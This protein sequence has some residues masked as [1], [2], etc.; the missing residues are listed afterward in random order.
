MARVTCIQVVQVVSEMDHQ[1]RLLQHLYSSICHCEAPSVVGLLN[2]DS[3]AADRCEGNL[4]D[5][6]RRVCHVSNTAAR[7]R[8]LA[9]SSLFSS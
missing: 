3:P 2:L 6:G 9:S 7:I 5:F 1:E 8:C 4:S